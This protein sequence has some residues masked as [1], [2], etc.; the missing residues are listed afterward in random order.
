MREKLKV[1]PTSLSA[2]LT[3]PSAFKSG[4]TTARDV[5]MA[6]MKPEKVMRLGATESGSNETSHRQNLFRTSNSV[7]ETPCERYTWVLRP[8]SWAGVSTNRISLSAVVLLSRRTA[9][10]LPTDPGDP[11]PHRL[12]FTVSQKNRFAW[13]VHVRSRPCCALIRVNRRRAPW[14]RLCC[15]ILSTS[16]YLKS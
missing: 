4:R 2:L 10:L 1:A 12:S 6:I 11:D 16:G 13:N 7:R 8:S 14:P 15:R 9:E 5:A 3:F